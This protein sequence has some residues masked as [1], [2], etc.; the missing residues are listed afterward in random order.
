MDRAHDSWDRADCVLRE[1]T[2]LP[3]TPVDQIFPQ[4]HRNNSP[5]FRLVYDLSLLL[6]NSLLDSN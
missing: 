6:D 5:G 2:A 1:R 3:A 4:E